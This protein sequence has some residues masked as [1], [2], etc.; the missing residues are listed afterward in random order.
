[1][2]EAEDIKNVLKSDP[3]IISLVDTYSGMVAVFGS[4]V[5]PDDFGG[6]GISMYRSSPLSAREEIIYDRI[7]INCYSKVRSNALEMQAAVKDALNRKSS[8]SAFYVCSLLP[9]ITSGESRDD[10]N[11][12]VEVLK[13]QR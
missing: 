13:R 5:M 8:G 11:A 12:P 6:D 2:I 1:M 4:P 10:Y 7:T 3:T 9:V